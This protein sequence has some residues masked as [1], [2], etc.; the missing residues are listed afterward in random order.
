MA[1]ETP[2]APSTPTPAAAA[3]S[4]APAPAGGGSQPSWAAPGGVSDFLSGATS[5]RP[6][7]TPAPS[8]RMETKPAETPA[9]APV[10]A[11]PSAP[12]VPSTPEPAKPA[13]PANPVPAA[14][15]GS[16]PAE[17][18]L[19]GRFKSAISGV[20]QD[21]GVK[22]LVQAYDAS[23]VEARR[24]LKV[25]A[26]TQEQVKAA[27]ALV[28][29]RDAELET[30]KLEKQLGPEI[31]DPTEAESANWTAKQWADHA[32]AKLQRSQLKDK[33]ETQAKQ[34]AES[35]KAST[36]ART[37]EVFSRMD[38]MRAQKEEFPGFEE[39]MAVDA[40]G[41]GPIANWMPLLPMLAGQPI[42][43]LAL[44]LISKGHEAVQKDKAAFL[45]SKR[46]KDDAAALVAASLPAAGGPG[47]AAVAQPEPAKP[48]VPADDS[49]AGHNARLIASHSWSKP[50]L[51]ID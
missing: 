14:P 2:S 32:V 28:A 25:A 27:V 16:A 47:G 19:A 31:K 5:E 18:M 17:I 29:A 12:P 24:L 37:Q 50:V 51:P 38:H 22:A 6:A 13:E 41:K 30:F 42:A 45:A 43:P 20:D 15:A 9:P 1:V 44:Y 49:D 4:S 46:S 35:T 11:A 8:T 33:L 40:D 10:A 23:G 3:P 39:A 7:A 26:E 36:A 21:P 48:P 34:T